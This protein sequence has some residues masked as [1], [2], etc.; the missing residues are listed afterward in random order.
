VPDVPRRQSEA[1]RRPDTRSGRLSGLRRHRARFIPFDLDSFAYATTD[2]IHAVRA[3]GRLRATQRRRPRL[4]RARRAPGIPVHRAMADDR[5]SGEQSRR[6]AAVGDDGPGRGSA[7]RDRR[8]S[9]RSAERT[10]RSRRI[11]TPA[12][13]SARD[14][15]ATSS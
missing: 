15:S 13:G 6:T 5:R 12:T 11:A 14:A 9:S 7:R 3:G 4:L 8:S 1:S 2:A 10:S